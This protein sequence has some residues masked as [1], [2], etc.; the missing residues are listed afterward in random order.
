MGWCGDRAANRWMAVHCLEIPGSA[1]AK[2]AIPDDKFL[3]ELTTCREPVYRYVLSMA[4]GAEGRYG[5][6]VN[7]GEDVR[8]RQVLATQCRR[9]SRLRNRNRAKT[10]PDARRTIVAGSGMPARAYVE[11]WSIFPQT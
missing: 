9:T 1:R 7:C 4:R 2:M 6:L 5:L 11:A 10:P 3:Q 8:K